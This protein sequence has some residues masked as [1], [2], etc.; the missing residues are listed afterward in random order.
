ME[1]P[2]VRATPL[3]TIS[4]GPQPSAATWPAVMRSPSSAMPMRSSCFALNSMP[5]RHGPPSDRKFIA[6][7]SNSANSMTGA[8]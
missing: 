6:I 8:P 3:T 5:A 1:A 2:I 7:P 4:T